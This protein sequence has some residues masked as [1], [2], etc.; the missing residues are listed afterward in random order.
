MLIEST[1]IK[2]LSEHESISVPVYGDTPMGA[3]PSAYILVQ[4]T[5]STVR[6]HIYTAMMAIQSIT[7]GSKADAATMNEAVIGAMRGL[8][9]CQNIFAS[10]LNSDYDYTDASTKQ[11]RYQAVFDI[12]YAREA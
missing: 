10:R 7:S 1:I 8:V 3:V 12:T 9:T 11:H 5:G 4:K 6:D 2:Y